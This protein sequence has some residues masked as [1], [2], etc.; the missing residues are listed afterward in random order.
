MKLKGKERQRIRS[1]LRKLHIKVMAG[2]KLDP[3]CFVGN[4]DIKKISD[5]GAELYYDA[6]ERCLKI[7]NWRKGIRDGTCQPN[8]Q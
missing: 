2:G 8:F 6:I 7:R 5:L 3:Y 1:F 4:K